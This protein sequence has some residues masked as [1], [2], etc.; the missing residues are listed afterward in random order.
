LTKAVKGPKHA[1]EPV[2]EDDE[3]PLPVPAK[4]VMTSA[5]I[6]KKVVKPLK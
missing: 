4:K 2:Q 5:K 3:A 6:V 1:A